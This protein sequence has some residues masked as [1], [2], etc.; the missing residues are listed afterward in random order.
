MKKIACLLAASGL[1]L[2]LS[3]GASA[4]RAEVWGYVDGK[5]IAHF[6]ASRLDEKYEL[7][8]RG[9][10]SFDTAEGLGNPRAKTATPRA[11]AVPTAAPKLIAF[12]EVAPNFKQ[13]KHHLRE[14]AK[15]QDI[16]Y[17]L[18]Q[19]LIATE[20]GFDASAVSQEY[21]RRRHADRQ[22]RQELVQIVNAAHRLFA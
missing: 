12:F 11:V 2:A 20:S 3:L 19:A 10:E 17:E 8:F 1:A 4:A 9:G 13:V 22:A 14:A 15:A 6:A 21:N 18:L 7:F 16:D 5:G